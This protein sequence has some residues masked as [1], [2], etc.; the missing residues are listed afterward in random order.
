[1]TLCFEL[2]L[3][4]FAYACFGYVAARPRILILCLGGIFGLI[5]GFSAYVIKDMPVMPSIVTE[6]VSIP[7]IAELSIALVIGTILY[8][9][10][11]LVGY[12]IGRVVNNV[13]KYQRK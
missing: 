6:G 1:M 5:A 11:F 13:E 2:I 7:R 12:Y 8:G 4:M 9:S 3:L 10:S